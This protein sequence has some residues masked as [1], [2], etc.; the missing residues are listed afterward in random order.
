MASFYRRLF[1]A[2]VFALCAGAS[3]LASGQTYPHQPI[4]L[5]VP[6]A[7]GGAVDQTARIISVALGEKLGQPIVI[8]NK[9]GAGGSIGAAEIAR[10]KPDGYTLMLALDT[11]AANYQIMKGL[12]YDTFKSFDYLN[13]LVTTPQILVTRGDLPVKNLE[14]LIA[15]LKAHP[16]TTYGTS[17]LASA[18]HVNSAQMALARQLKT[19]HVPYKGAAP[20]ITDLLG[21]HIDFAFA[22][23]SV[24]LPH[25]QAG[26]VRAIAVGSSKRS[27]L[28]PGVPTMSESIPGLEYP[29][30]VGLVAPSGL[31]AD[32]RNKIVAATSEVMRNPEV[33]KHFAQNGFD[34]VNSTPDAFKARLAKDA[35]TLEDLIR[36]KVLGSEPI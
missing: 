5:I 29:T 16:G 27:A 18:G 2:A 31:P 8:E 19:T 28:L 32:T 17:G 11:Q 12:R 14:E 24:L 21:G 7:P 30:W 22:G 4:R 6:F 13:L 15:Y 35:G 36:R 3:A 33:A 26:K 25:I 10:A 23:I 1:N 34:I 20:M 9:P